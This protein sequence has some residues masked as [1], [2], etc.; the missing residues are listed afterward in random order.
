MNIQTIRQTYDLP[1]LTGKDTN[2]TPFGYSNVFVYLWVA[3]FSGVMSPA[4]Y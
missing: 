2:L 1:S 3:Q 4:E